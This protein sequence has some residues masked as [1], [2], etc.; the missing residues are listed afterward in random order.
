MILNDNE[1]TNIDGLIEPFNASL[2]EKGLS[3]GLSSFGYDVTLSDIDF[4]VSST[5]A[6][7]NHKTIIDPK[8]FNKRSL[9]AVDLIDESY[10]IL[11]AL[12]FGLGVTQEKFSLPDN[13]TGLI[14]P[15]STYERVGVRLSPTVIESGFIGHIVL[16]FFN[17]SNYPVRI[18]AKEGIG[19]IIFLKG[20]SCKTSYGIRGGKYQFQSEK[21]TVAKC[22]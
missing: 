6:R 16:E 2:I 18:Y 9:M 17:S 5:N 15:K 14:F 20:N 3:Y 22:L 10:F 21:I 1:I 12:T 11:P 4:R 7:L 8:N 13:L 19:Q